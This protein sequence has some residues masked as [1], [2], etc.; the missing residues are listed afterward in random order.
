MS[1]RGMADG[2]ERVDAWGPTGERLGT[3][4]LV[5]D[6]AECAEL[7]RRLSYL[8]DEL[9]T[10]EAEFTSTGRDLAVFRLAYVRRFGP[11]YAEL[12]RLEAEIASRILA[13]DESAYTRERAEEAAQR[14]RRS[15]RL[16]EEARSA[17]PE[18]APRAAAGPELKE[19]YRRAARALHPDLALEE[20]ERARRTRAMAALNTAYADRDA[21]AMERL[22][23]GA[24]DV[25][26]PRA[27]A[28]AASRS[29]SLKRQIDQ[30]LARLA[31]L[32]RQLADLRGDPMFALFEIARSTMDGSDP[33]ADDEAD[34]RRRI[35]SAR[36]Q[37]AALS[38]PRP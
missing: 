30:V 32:D 15:E 22:L 12:D 21:A 24:A 8:L 26:A 2:G 16:A 1:S 5:D 4:A 9:A 20:G 25:A 31:E 29:R 18:K 13:A 14:A 27:R 36:A 7:E 6:E 28:G 34:L 33:F 35:A 38:D 17:P 10:R 11:L 23:A 19:L 3:V 37:L